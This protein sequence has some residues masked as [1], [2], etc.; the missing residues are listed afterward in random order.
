MVMRLKSDEEIVKSIL[1]GNDA[2]Y[3]LLIDR[4]KDKAFALSL[5]MIKNNLDAEEILQESFIKAYNSLGQFK[6]ESKFSTWFYRI[7]YNNALTF[8]RKKK[9]NLSEEIDEELLLAN[10]DAEHFK[11]LEIKDLHLFLNK[12]ILK[13]PEKYSSVLTMFYINELSLEEISELS[14]FTL[15]SVKVNLFRARNMLR[16]FV[17]KNNYVRELI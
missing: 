12:L 1:R 5:R 8:L 17:L 13:L 16:D 7:V 4:Y 3:K 10:N 2:E 6:F 15:S 9:I 11:E 14:G